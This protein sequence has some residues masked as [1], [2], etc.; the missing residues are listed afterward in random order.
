MVTQFL[1]YGLI[2]YHIM[3]TFIWY[4]NWILMWE[5]YDYIYHHFDFTLNYKKKYK[6]GISYK[7]FILSHSV[8]FWKTH[9]TP[10]S[11]FSHNLF[12]IYHT[13]SFNS[14]YYVLLHWYR[15]PFYFPLKEENFSTIR[16]RTQD[17]NWYHLRDYYVIMK[18]F[19]IVTEHLYTYIYIL[20]ISIQLFLNG[21][22]EPD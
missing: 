22:L 13:L 12:K 3:L 21:L 2:S 10:T 9:Y 7:N 17:N 5:K 15:C 16:F 4:F 20:S 19:Q 14:L 18:Q 1:N 6:I 11:S 8:S